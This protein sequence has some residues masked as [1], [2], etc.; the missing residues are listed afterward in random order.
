MFT[1]YSLFH[2]ILL[3]VG[4][5]MQQKIEYKK[6][7]AEAVPCENIPVIRQLVLLSTDCNCGNS[8]IPEIES[9][10]AGFFSVKSFFICN[11]IRSFKYT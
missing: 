7:T 4:K 10:E 5:I 1:K 3:K 9:Y 6:G 8:I 11:G 2:N